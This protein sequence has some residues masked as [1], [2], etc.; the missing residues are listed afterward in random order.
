[1]QKAVMMI[2]SKPSTRTLR[3]A[4]ANFAFFM[5]L[6]FFQLQMDGSGMSVMTNEH[7]KQPE[8]WQMADAKREI[9]RS[10]HES[11]DA[12]LEILEKN[13]DKFTDFTENYS[14]Q[15]KELLVHNASDFNNCYT[16]FTSR[17]TFLALVPTIRQVEPKF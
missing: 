2:V 1:M 17:Q 13:P 7:R 4:I 16:I 15:Y 11:M 3:S 6:P 12:L 5:Y 10:G 14:T 9:L 8:W